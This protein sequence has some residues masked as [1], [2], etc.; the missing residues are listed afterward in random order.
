MCQKELEVLAKYSS[1]EIEIVEG[2]VPR[3]KVWVVEVKMGQKVDVVVV[4][5]LDLE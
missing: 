4:G 3:I 1:F 5:I 2:A